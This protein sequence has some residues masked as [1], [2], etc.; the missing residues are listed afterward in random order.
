MM[1]MTKDC[2]VVILGQE[3]TLM[4]DEPAEQ[5]IHAATMVDNSLKEILSKGFSDQQKGAVLSAL[6]FANS[7][8]RLE[9][10]AQEIE[11]RNQRLLER[12]DRVMQQ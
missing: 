9:K 2:K 4:T 11:E 12:I 1:N 8:R 10:E 7:V 6:R 3:Y 5:V